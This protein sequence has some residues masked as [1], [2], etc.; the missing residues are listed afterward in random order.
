MTDSIKSRR[1]SSPFRGGVSRRPFKAAL[2]AREN[3]PA[4]TRIH[5]HTH[6][7]TLGA[8]FRYSSL[9]DSAASSGNSGWIFAAVKINPAEVGAER[10]T[11]ERFS[12]RRH[13]AAQERPTRKFTVFR[14]VSPFFA[15]SSPF[16][17]IIAAHSIR[18]ADRFSPTVSLMLQSSTNGVESSGRAGSL[19]DSKT[20][21]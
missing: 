20:L 6:T 11:N 7:C 17:R 8:R 5:T 15:A 10:R 19:A 4:S 18:E 3:A 13:L 12:C 14:Y 16:H 2:I 21:R 1:C 9:E